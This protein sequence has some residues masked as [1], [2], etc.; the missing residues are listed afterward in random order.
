MGSLA[1]AL[2]FERSFT[3]GGVTFVARRLCLAEILRCAVDG[4]KATKDATDEEALDIAE[5]LICGEQVSFPQAGI[6]AL[7]VAASDGLDATDAKALAIL[8]INETRRICRFILGLMEE[9][10]EPEE[11]KAQPKKKARRWIGSR[12]IQSFASILAKASAS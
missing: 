12:W 1:D 3:V 7:I 10:P 2:N 8:G 4:V 9:D 5:G 11:K 6:E